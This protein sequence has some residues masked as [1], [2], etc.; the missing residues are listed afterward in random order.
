M[1]IVKF[2][3]PDGRQINFEIIKV[4]P[5]NVSRNV[6]PDRHRHEFYSIFFVLNGISTQEI[7]FDKYDIHKNQIVFIPKGSIH[8]EIESK[9]LESYILLFKDEFL[10]KPMMDMINGFIKYAIFQRKLVLDLSEIQTQEFIKIAEVIKQEHN[11]SDH[12]NLIFI[13]QNLLLVWLNK[14]ESIAQNFNS[15][16]TFVN[17]GILFQQ[18]ASL[19]DKNFAKHKDIAFYCTELGCTSKKLSQV[20]NEIMGKPTNEIII[21]TIILEAKRKLCYSSLSIK[22]IAFELGYDNPFYFSRIFKTKEKKSP[23]EFRKQF[24]L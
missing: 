19:L 4:L 15:K 6:T 17:N 2:N 20:L 18:F 9:N 13:L 10:P 23:E 5:Q 3:R 14:M 12:Q 11:Q 22:E 7:D 1:K 24:A 8:W 21:D 16:N